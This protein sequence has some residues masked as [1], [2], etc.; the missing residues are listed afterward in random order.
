MNDSVDQTLKSWQDLASRE[1]AGDTPDDL[2]W[3]TPEGIRI[4]TLYTREDLEALDHQ[5]GLPGLLSLIHI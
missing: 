4:K 1:L 2:E 5:D 3:S